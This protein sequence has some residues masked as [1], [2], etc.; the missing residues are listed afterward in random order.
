[1]LI[2]K[3]SKM[4]YCMSKM[5][6]QLSHLYSSP[7]V[8]ETPCTIQ[9]TSFIS[10][11]I[12][13]FCSSR[14][15][16]HLRLFVA[17]STDS[18][19]SLTANRISRIARTEAQVA[20]FDYLHSTRSFHFTDADHISK[21]SPHFLQNLLSRVENQPDV[22]RAVSKFLRY[23]PIN[24]FEPFLE[25]LGLTSSELATLLPRNL[26][27]LSD[28]PIML[29][30]FHI[31]CNY[32]IPRSKI[33]K[34]FKEAN[35]IFQYGY[36]VLDLKLR[37]Y[38]ELG[39][40]RSALI[41]LFTCCPSLLVGGVNKEFVGVLEKLIGLGF[42]TDWIQGYLSDKNTYNWNRVLETMCFLGEVGYNE[43]QMG[44]LFKTNPALLFEG[45]GERIFVLVG[46]LLKLGL[47]MN[48]V[49]NLFLQNPQ[50]LSAK[51]ANNHW[52]AVCFLIEIG[53]ETEDIANI[54][55][56]HMQLLC[57]N[58]LKGPKTV[59]KNLGVK[60]ESLC[61]IIKEDPLK[62]ISLASKSNING[63]ELVASQNAS[64]FLEKTTFLL[65]L[66]Y[67]ENSD[68]MSKALKQFRGR[69]DQLQERFDCL[70]QAGLD[71]NVVSNMIKQAPAVLNQTKD[72]LEKKIDCLRN[73]LGYPLESIVAFPSYLCYDME[74]INLRFSMYAW[75]R[76]RGAAKPTLSLS[77][78]L[79]CSDVR[80]VKYFVDVHPE[81]P[82]MS[83]LKDS[84]SIM[85]D[86]LPSPS[87]SS[88]TTPS[89]S[90]PNPSFPN[91]SHIISVKLTSE[92]YLLW[93]VQIV[94]YLRGQRLYKFVDGSHPAPPCYLPDKSP[95]PEYET[96]VDYDQMVMSALISSLSESI[97]AEVVGC[98]SARDVWLSLAK[99]YASTSQ[100]RVVQTQLQLASL[101]K[102]SDSISVYYRR[103]KS[104]VDSMAAAGR[105][106]PSSE[107][108]P[109]L[110]A[111]LGPDYDP[112][113]S[114]VTTRIEP[115]GTEELLGHLLS[116][117]ACLH[118]HATKASL[119][120]PTEP[121]AHFASRG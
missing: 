62:F 37:A 88:L 45:S 94:P 112:L 72:V 39:L 55:S 111:G 101:N 70:V 31:L 84:L 89:S 65:G 33:G 12:R 78:I 96:W 49:Y 13:C 35:E 93:Q 34:M 30:N 10:Q 41:K 1:M 74:R 36:E 90:L 46:R 26:M 9:S 58:S 75:L 23:N 69:G 91:L 67:V 121:S 107:F 104:L 105:P 95:N 21:N 29:D 87:S 27:F 85:A 42:G 60:K 68:E 73:C 48:K 24:E 19:N 92:N 118:H 97:I 11:H 63:I 119:F 71:C 4:V 77:T 80:F 5:I 86:P 108:V 16:R 18:S 52:Q 102:G 8:S 103:A 98:R 79:A 14:P 66:G 28:D 22:S 57:S 120:S 110:L 32:G 83:H 17:D 44:N 50:I 114:S 116:H 100:A 38:E 117:E 109:Y 25:S 43:T 56:T 40:S 7:V 81:G 59:L 53:M 51:C 106:L 3:N 76:K 115:I 64:K 20:L 2:R 6:S 61:Q 113:V 47:K 15:V 99:T 54:V 82:T